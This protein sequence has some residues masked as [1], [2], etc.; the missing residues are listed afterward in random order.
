MEPKPEENYYAILNIPTNASPSEIT[1]AYHAAK[2]A[3]SRDS[4]ATYTLFTAED[5]KKILD[6]IEKA[7]LHLANIEKRKN[8]DEKITHSPS[9]S[10]DL[11]PSFPIPPK[12]ED[13]PTL[14]LEAKVPG[15]VSGEYLKNTREQQGL[16]PEDVSRI[17]KIPTRIIK[18][19]EAENRP[20]LPARVYV[21]GFVK[22]LAK[23]YRLAPSPIA[24]SYVKHLETHGKLS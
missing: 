15:T 24:D 21:Q 4:V 3:F 11:K 10:S 19:I 5:A 2:S 1:A 7:Y 22:N 17:T 14:E 8:Y 6:R 9:K 20:K 23:L 18:A 12:E 16:T 13:T